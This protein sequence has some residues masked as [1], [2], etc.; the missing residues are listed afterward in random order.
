MQVECKKCAGN[1][2]M[3]PDFKTNQPKCYYCRHGMDPEESRIQNEMDECWE[4]FIR[5]V[6]GLSYADPNPDAILSMSI[7]RETAAEL[8]R[9]E[10][11]KFF[12]GTPSSDK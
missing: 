1:F 5:T 6:T 10:A 11:E 7:K 12:F 4:F 8:Q 9:I 2:N 3:N